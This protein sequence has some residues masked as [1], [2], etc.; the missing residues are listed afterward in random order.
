MDELV[1]TVYFYNMLSSDDY[2]YT[3]MMGYAHIN[4]K[5]IEAQ[6]GKSKLSFRPSALAKNPGTGEWYILSSVNK[7][8]VIAD[9][10]W[11][12]KSVYPLQS[13]LF[14]QPEGIAFDNQN[15]LYISNEG[16]ELHQGTILK[17]N[18]KK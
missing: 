10:A 9:A 17:F 16:D 14:V 2:P 13:S 4:V 11:H 7:A 3:K 8:L 5:D 1:V 18:F 6:L 15:N 12:V